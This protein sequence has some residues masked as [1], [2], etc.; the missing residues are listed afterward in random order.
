MNRQYNDWWN[1]STYAAYKRGYRRAYTMLWMCGAFL[2]LAWVGVML[3]RI[4]SVL[5]DLAE[6]PPSS[7]R[8]SHES[9]RRTF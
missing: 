1:R 8:C 5:N 6:R 7:A 9:Y 4:D 2:W 3:I